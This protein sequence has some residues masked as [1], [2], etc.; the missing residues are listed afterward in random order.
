MMI[1]TAI[2]MAVYLAILLTLIQSGFTAVEK[3]KQE[4]S[5]FTAEFNNWQ[6][7]QEATLLGETSGTAVYNT[8]SG[9]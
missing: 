3:T 7:C 2:V 6:N 9:C 8:S 4:L 1:K 5:V